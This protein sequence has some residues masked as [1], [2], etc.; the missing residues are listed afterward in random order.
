MANM[1]SAV[2]LF[3]P[4][5]RIR[6]FIIPGP[7]IP[8]SRFGARSENGSANVFF[9]A[10]R[11]NIIFLYPISKKKV[12]LGSVFRSKND[13]NRVRVIKKLLSTKERNPIFI[14]NCSF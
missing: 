5:L 12:T 7:K 14:E 9:C 3:I 2:G 11:A 8:H 4:M 10:Y 6:F 1:C 13:E